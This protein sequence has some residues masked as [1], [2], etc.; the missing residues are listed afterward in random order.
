MNVIYTLTMAVWVFC[1]MCSAVELM[2]GGMGNRDG[3]V[4]K[5]IGGILLMAVASTGVP[6][7]E[8]GV[9]KNKNHYID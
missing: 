2:D 8:P 7:A 9:R 5:I 1:R 3:S 4:G 6:L